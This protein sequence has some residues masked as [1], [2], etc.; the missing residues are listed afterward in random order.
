MHTFASYSC[1]IHKNRDVWTRNKVLVPKL[2]SL[3]EHRSS[4]FLNEEIKRLIIFSYY[5][6]IILF[7]NSWHLSRDSVR[8]PAMHLLSFFLFPIYVLNN[9]LFKH[10]IFLFDYFCSITLSVASNMFFI[11]FNFLIT[12]WLNNRKLV[13]LV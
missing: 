3:N 12:S 6:S 13:L 8:H 9:K 11:C 1:T 7:G 4:W 10:Y 5:F 2:F